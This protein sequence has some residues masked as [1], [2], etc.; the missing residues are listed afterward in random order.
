MCEVKGKSRVGPDSPVLSSDGK[1]VRG[2][3]CVSKS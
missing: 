3:F 1:P 2:I